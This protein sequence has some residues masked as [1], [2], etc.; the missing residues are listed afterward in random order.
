MS[1]VKLKGCPSYII[2]NAPDYQGFQEPQFYC[3]FISLVSMKIKIKPI[4]GKAT[5]KADGTAQ[6]IQFT[7]SKNMV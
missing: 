7:E 2:V 5:T 1:D 3:N 4:F 6:A